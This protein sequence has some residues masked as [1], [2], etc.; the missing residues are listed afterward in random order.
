MTVLR[1]L[2][3][4]FV[5]AGEELV[6]PFDLELHCGELATHFSAGAR[7]AALSARIAAAVVKPTTG[8]AYIGDFDTHLQAA[9]AK[10]CVAF[11]S[12]GEREP[13]N[14][15]RALDFYVAA[16]DVERGE[17]LRRANEVLSAL[18]GGAYGRNAALALSHDPSLIVLERPAPGV[19]ETLALLRPRAAIL[20]SHVAPGT[21][22]ALAGERAL[23]ALR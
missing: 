11:V 15:A 7:G 18:G 10:R 9:Q 12:A 4:N 5:R 6:P 2:R 14:F 1:I 19:V 8:A 17:G 21:L 20:C 13:G 3:A 23:E 22:E 16:F